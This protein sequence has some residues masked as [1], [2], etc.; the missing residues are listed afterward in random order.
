MIAC[1]RA[2]L[3][4]EA[5]KLDEAAA[6]AWWINDKIGERPVAPRVAH[7][8]LVLGRVEDMRGHFDVAGQHYRRAADMAESM[9]TGKSWRARILLAEVLT[10]LERY[11]DAA[12]VLD[13]FANDVNIKPEHQATAYRLMAT[14]AEAGNDIRAVLEYEREGFAIEREVLESRAEQSLRNSRVMAQTELLE[15]EAE[16]E[17]ERR[18]RLERELADAVVALGDRERLVRTVE[19]RLRTAL[20]RGGPAGQSATTALREALASL[21]ADA[22]TKETPLH[23][24]AGVEDDFYRR[25]RERYP[26][27][28]RKQERLCGLLR[29]GLD[30]KEIALLMELGPDGVKAQRKRLRK[31]L[32]LEQEE[33]LESL[34]AEI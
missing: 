13:G 3:L 33:S 10:K 14:I 20:A 2:E 1:R 17:R 23:Y 15:R 11:D 28:T 32:G 5:G 7:A 9:H 4:I 6:L 16:L 29:S 27:L 8:Y 26:G 21:R 18:R 25:L 22:A 34:M 19:E 30:S 12:D 31:R 24:L